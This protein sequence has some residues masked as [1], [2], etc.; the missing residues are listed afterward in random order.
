M[1]KIPPSCQLV[2]SIPCRSCLDVNAEWSLAGTSKEPGVRSLP[3]LASSPVGLEPTSRRW[4]RVGIMLLSRYPATSTAKTY[5]KIIGMILLFSGPMLSRICHDPPGIH[6]N[7][8]T[9]DAPHCGSECD[10]VKASEKKASM[11]TLR[12]PRRRDERGNHVMRASVS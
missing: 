11:V 3:C 5:W 12:Y 2:P 4:S 10:D 8:K 6:R 1:D 7:V 9:N